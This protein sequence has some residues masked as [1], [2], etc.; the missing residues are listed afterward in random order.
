[1]RNGQTGALQ[2]RNKQSQLLA[3]GV[4][5]GA[6]AV[7]VVTREEAHP[8]AGDTE[9]QQRF[10]ASGYR[11]CVL[12]QL[13]VG[14]QRGG[15]GVG[16]TVFGQPTALF[17]DAGRCGPLAPA[18]AGHGSVLVRQRPEDG[19]PEGDAAILL[20]EFGEYELATRGAHRRG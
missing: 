10:V 5:G 2:S 11:P 16:G 4:G 9:G 17:L 14:R 8:T 12:E 1:M 6:S 13:L 20:V 18:Q 3:E 19:A 15:I 7:T